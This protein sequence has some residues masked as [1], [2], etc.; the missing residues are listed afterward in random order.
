MTAPRRRVSRLT[1]EQRSTRARLAAL[2]RWSKLP[3]EERAAATRPAR[4]ALAAKWDRSPNPD[5]AKRAHMT[6]LALSSSRSRRAADH[7]PDL[8]D[9]P[10]A[11]SA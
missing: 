10:D 7:S 8:L 6:R 3:P 5:A 9:Q 1:P 2:S 11:R 4:D